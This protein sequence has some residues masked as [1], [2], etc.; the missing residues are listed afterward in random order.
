MADRFLRE[1]KT[2]RRNIIPV[3]ST[4]TTLTYRLEPP[5]T[6]E[7]HRIST[8]RSTWQRSDALDTERAQVYT[9]TSRHPRKVSYRFSEIYN[10]VWLFVC[11]QFDIIS[12]F[13]RI[14]SP[15]LYCA[16]ILF[17]WRCRIRST[18]LYRVRTH[19]TI[20]EGVNH[21]CDQFS[22]PDHAGRILHVQLCQYYGKHKKNIN[23]FYRNM[24]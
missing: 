12:G 14:L 24:A 21:S 5:E 9:T 1:H 10:F 6:A 8:R 17:V 2:R 23:K 16:R 22:Q 15:T 4:L 13:R 19:S 11:C 20:M 7:S 3:Y 18:S